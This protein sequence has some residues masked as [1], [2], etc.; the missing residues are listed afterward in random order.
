MPPLGENGKHIT[1]PKK[2]NARAT[3]ARLTELLKRI[4]GLGS[5]KSV[6]EIEREIRQRRRDKIALKRD[7]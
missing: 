3:S 1:I 5:E 6:L 7:A 4:V 2:P